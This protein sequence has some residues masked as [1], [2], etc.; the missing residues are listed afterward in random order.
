MRHGLTRRR[1]WIADAPSTPKSASAMAIA[2]A[3]KC[4]YRSTDRGS[5]TITASQI[6]HW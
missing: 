5:T 1:T 6:W 2:D 3:E 4:R